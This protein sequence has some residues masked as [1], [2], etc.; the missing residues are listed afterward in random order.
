MLYSSLSTKFDRNDVVS[1]RIGMPIFPRDAFARKRA[2]LTQE[3][4]QKPGRVQAYFRLAHLHRQQGQYLQAE[5]VL[6]RLLGREIDCGQRCEAL[7][8]LAANC[9]D[10]GDLEQATQ[11]WQEAATLTEDPQADARLHHIQGRIEMERHRLT[12]GEGEGEALLEDAIRSLRYAATLNCRP[13]LLASIYYHLAL[14]YRKAGR[15]KPAIDYLKRAVRLEPDDPQQVAACYLELGRIELE[16]RGNVGWAT[17]LF[18]L[19][20][21]NSPL[22]APSNWLSL[23]HCCLSRAYSRAGQTRRALREARKCQRC[24]HA[25][26]DDH[27]ER[28]FD[29]HEQLG[30]AYAARRRQE[31]PAIEHYRQA[32]TVR[33]DP[34]IY[35]RLGGIY[36]RQGRFDEAIE[37]FKAMLDH[38]PAYAHPGDVYHAMGICLSEM[39]RYDEALACFRQAREEQATITF[40]PHEIYSSEG[41]NYW[42]M[43]RLEDAA[44]AFKTAL[45]LMHPRD[46]ERRRIEPWL[47]AVQGQMAL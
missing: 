33:T 44:R 13:G 47:R 46:R 41:I 7:L 18:Q 35:R 12:T 42:R 5:A 40:R 24:L 2:A 9:L 8:R 1:K 20:L 29:A 6:D 36:S 17:G 43:G 37:M 23:V 27:A 25:G 45:G 16:D 22:R 3:I 32:L 11:H 19:A 21:Q 28:L 14:A 38:E 10:R 31:E 30:A 39:G 26:E 34:E 15:T 4:T